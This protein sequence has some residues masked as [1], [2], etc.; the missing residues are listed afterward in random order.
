MGPPWKGTAQG[1]IRSFVG[2]DGIDA[3]GN[4]ANAVGWERNGGI[5]LDELI[6]NEST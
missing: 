3:I 5:A 2:R 1:A 4:S 6:R